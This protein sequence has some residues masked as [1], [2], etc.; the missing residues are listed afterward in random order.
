MVMK[1][2]IRLFT[3]L[4]VASMV[5]ASCNQ[6]EIETPSRVDTIKL[7]VTAGDIDSKTA[8]VDPEDGTYGLKWTAGDQLGVFEV[9]D[10]TVQPKQTSAE[11]D[12]D[13]TTKTFTFTLNSVA[14]SAYDYSF[15]Y[16]AA[17]LTKGGNNESPIYRIQ[18]PSSQT[19]EANSFDKDAD[20]LVSE[21]KTESAQPSE[22]SLRFS[23]I[24]A[25]AR[26]VLTGLT[27]TE[28]IKQVKFSTTEGNISGYM[29]I[30]PTTGDIDANDEGVYSGEKYIELTPAADDLQL[31]GNVV[32][33]FRLYDIT[34]VNNFTV[35]VKTDAAEYTKSVDL[36]T[37]S[38]TLQF[39]A[40]ALTKFNVNLSTGTDRVDLNSGTT[41]NLV[42][43]MS[44]FVEGAKYIFVG[45]YATGS[46]SYAQFDAM[47]LQSSSYRNSVNLIAV[48]DEIGKTDI[49]SSIIVPT[50]KNV[51][52]VEIGKIGDNYY[53]KDV[54]SNSPN[55]GKYLAVTADS[56]AINISEDTSTDGAQWGISFASSVVT[57]QNKDTGKN[58]RLLVP[59][60]SSTRFA[61]YKTAQASNT[62][63]L[64]IDPTSYTAEPTIVA[65][66]ASVSDV[67][68][69]GVTDAEDITFELKNFD[70]TPT[71]TVTCDGTI[72]TDATDVDD[73]IVYSVS[74]NSGSSGRD[75]WI[76]ISAG[77]KETTI[78]VSQNGAPSYDITLGD[79][80]DG[81]VY[82][83][84]N[85]NDEVTFSVTSN[86]SWVAD[87]NY[88]GGVTDSYF[89]DPEDGNAL[90]DESDITVITVTAYETNIESADRFLGTIIIDN[91]GESTSSVAVWQHGAT[92]A[93][94]SG[95]ILWQEDFTGYGTAMP[96]SA[97]GSHVY[98]GGTVTYELI[99]S[100]TK[101]YNEALAGGIAPE[102]FI[103]KGDGAY[104]IS[105]IPTGN[106]SAMTLFFKSNYGNRCS[107]STATSGITKGSS[108][109]SN[110]VV[111]VVFSVTGSVSSFD[112]TISD[113][114]AS[115]NVRIDN[116][117]LV[118]G[119]VQQLTMSEVTC[120]DPGENKNSLTFTW[121]AVDNATGY[122]VSIDGG[123]TFGSTIT[124]TSYTWTGLDEGTSHTLFVKAIGNGT[125]YL[126][127]YAVSA[128]GTTKSD[129]F[130]YTLSTT[131]NGSN[132]AYDK[133]YDVTINGMSWNAPGNQNNDGFWRIGGKSISSVAR[134][135]KANAGI[136]GDVN[137]I[138]IN[139]NGKSRNNVTL[140]GIT[141]KAYTDDSFSETGAVTFTTSDSLTL[142]KTAEHNITFT[143]SGSTNVTGYYFKIVFTV[144]NSDTS[145]GGVDLT[146]IVFA[147]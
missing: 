16:P 117:I 55:N 57:I 130:I 24:G 92:P 135:I 76:K 31:T 131:K 105:G 146:S 89:I 82:V 71:V 60:I 87:Y 29:K 80:T 5:F 77:E 81:K 118:A 107:I 11:L 99:S 9:V 45:R 91:G 137:T 120:S 32:I 18:I 58:S 34:L 78:S 115:N 68:Y 142:P 43:N 66:P 124:A 114:D 98:G 30:N 97:T 83:G 101:L 138:T 110:G 102:L 26:M 7:E 50:E 72:V 53:I 46:M 6:S 12:S 10:G 54:Y 47:G 19:F 133:T 116:I 128:S 37:A 4:G 121:G 104:E 96:A 100:S 49:P 28:V 15:V 22:L 70:T 64:Y 20:L 52:P 136:G 23:R 42:S 141:V 95:T 59:N 69:K 44:E 85:E 25:T 126:D 63:L 67:S 84:A 140:N 147:E 123:S 127:S 65:T 139:T 13:G 17:A 51:N 93:A 36:A 61:A 111:R 143:K 38:R 21:H 94:A 125:T 79:V 108:S 86:Y 75:G 3:T 14:G 35:F 145:N 129:T 48:S 39:Q 106:A 8:I 112:L 88:T 2:I 62:M 73:K 41:Y 40:G 144:S 33:W 134:T 122:Q 132:S 90:D 103:S 1:Q 113:S 119:D 56:N 109:V 74:E 27:T